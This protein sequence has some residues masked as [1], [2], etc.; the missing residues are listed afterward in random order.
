MQESYV[1]ALIGAAAA[2]VGGGLPVA[3]QRYWTVRSQ[4]QALLHVEVRFFP[5]VI[6][7]YLRMAISD[8]VND[9]STRPRP[10][11]IAKQRLL[12]VRRADGYINIRIKNNCK[13]CFED[14]CLV[15]RNG[16]D[17]VY[18][19]SSNGH[20]AETKF[21][22]QVEIGRIIPGSEYQ[23]KIWYLFDLS[24][25]IS[26]FR[27]S[28]TIKAREYDDIL[29]KYPISEYLNSVYIINQKS[30]NS[31]L[32]QFAKGAFCAVILF[33]LF[34]LYYRGAEHASDHN[35]GARFPLFTSIPY[36]F[37]WGRK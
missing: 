31:V 10:S 5:F 7:E 11:R 32:A 17:I 8:Y 19:I 26:S 13:V 34:K 25:S 28:I 20:K 16:S 27:N 2:L 18:D 29:V 3:L 6:P 37:E 15:V 12:E 33:I 36:Q 4:K 1:I 35:A 23:I 9:Y 21:G 14:V 24:E 22:T 30:H